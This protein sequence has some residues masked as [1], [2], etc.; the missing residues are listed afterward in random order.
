MRLSVIYLLSAITFSFSVTAQSIEEFI[1]MN[2]IYQAAG[3][4]YVQAMKELED[5]KMVSDDQRNILITSNN[6]FLDDHRR[7][8][9]EIKDLQDS[10][11][12]PVDSDFLSNFLN[13][14]QKIISDEYL[15]VINEISRKI[16]PDQLAAIDYQH[17]L[18]NNRSIELESKKTVNVEICDL[19]NGKKVNA[20]K[21]KA[22]P[23]TEGKNE[24]KVEGAAPY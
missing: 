21:S 8:E 11:K 4:K 7:L 1:K 3:E 20:K 14:S 2:I 22:K 5:N 6:Q 17:L 15:K 13:I 12:Y 23:E 24:D 18:L 16:K 9:Q 10:C 19:K